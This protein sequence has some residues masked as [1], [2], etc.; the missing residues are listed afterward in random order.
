MFT[1]FEL[2]GHRGA[3]GLRPENTLPS[4]EAALDAGANAV[5]T[6]LHRTHDGI[7]VVCHDPQLSG[8]LCSRLPFPDGTPISRLTVAQ[9]RAYR[10]DRNP[11][12]RRFPEQR[13]EVTPV[14]ALFAAQHGLDPFGIP[15]LADLF[16]FVAAYAGPLGERAGKSEEQRGRA[17]QLRFDLELK[18][19]PFHPEAMGDEFDGVR[20]GRLEQGVVQAVREASVVERTRV[21]SFDHRCVRA[22]RQLEPGI[23]GAILIAETALVD[24]AEVTRRAEAAVCCP[25]YLFLDEE[26]VQSAHAGGVRVVPWTA[27]DAMVWERLLAWG[28]DGLATDYPDRLAAYL[29]SRHIEY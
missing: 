19:V 14:A 6:D 25:N 27:N 10:A 3:R 29:R 4:F 2:Q 20:A 21:R 1:H 5:E 7:V 16:A 18:R 24:P 13:P 8:R 23:E 26:Q 9:L 12:P 22:L 28:V 11:D 17:Q 15:T